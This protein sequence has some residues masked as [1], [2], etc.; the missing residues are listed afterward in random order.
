MWK[1]TTDTME[2]LL[3][4]YPEGATVRNQ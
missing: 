3:G 1:A 4:K 2:L